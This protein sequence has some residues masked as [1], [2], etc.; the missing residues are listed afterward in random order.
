MNR[1]LF[2]TSSLLL[3]IGVCFPA[4]A[5]PGKS[6]EAVVRED[7]R[8]LNE[9]DMVGLLAVFSPNAKVFS[10]PEDPD[11]LVG[12]LSDKIGT[13]AQ[14]KRAFKANPEDQLSRVEIVDTV[15]LGELVVTTLKFTDPPDHSKSTYSLNV[16]RVRA[17]LIRDLWHVARQEDNA[18]RSQAAAKEVIQRLASAHNRGDAEALLALFS[19]DAKHFRSSDDP[20]GLANKPWAGA[21][22]QASRARVFRA[23][24]AKGPPS[25]VEIVDSLA[26]GDLVASRDRTTLSNGKIVDRLSIY[27]VQNG[28]IRN[29]WSVLERPR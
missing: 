16:F 23:M 20:D 24:F 2:I 4:M 11:R 28:V 26:L 18:A 27:R 29:E 21:I 6:P 22:D 3:L 17:G 9:G 15:A 1:L 13:H 19:P 14:R 8:A 25:R 5:Q 10:R 7:V 12:K